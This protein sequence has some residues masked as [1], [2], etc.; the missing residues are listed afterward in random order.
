MWHPL[1][2]VKQGDINNLFSGIR[3]KL[4]TF[5][6]I[7]NKENKESIVASF[8]ECVIQG[9]FRMGISVHWGT[10]PHASLCAP[11]THSSFILENERG[12]WRHLLGRAGKWLYAQNSYQPWQRAGEGKG[13]EEEGLP[14]TPISWPLSQETW[15][16][17][18]DLPLFDF[19]P[20]HTIKPSGS[21]FMAYKV[22]QG[23]V[24]TT[25]YC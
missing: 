14:T 22:V 13:T 3:L 1:Y 23:F 4:L 9:C 21:P 17:A 6:S 24:Q 20:G 7:S 10:F 18:L 5:L 8:Q 25:A 15:V 16:L 2:M 19:S 12:S 11:H